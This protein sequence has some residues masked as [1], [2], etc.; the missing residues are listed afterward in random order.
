[1]KI[2]NILRMQVAMMGFAGMMFLA[3]AAPA[4]EITNTEWPDAPGATESVQ[5]AARPV[6][7][8]GNT[9]VTNSTA[10]NASVSQDAAVSPLSTMEGWMVGSLVVFAAMVGWFKRPAARRVNQDLKSRM[11]R[12]VAIS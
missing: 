3:S 1:M 2:Q 5:A 8:E 10:V 11:R 7:S 4:Q 12:E 9:A 6:A